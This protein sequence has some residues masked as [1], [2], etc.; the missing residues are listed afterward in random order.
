ME[1]EKDSKDSRKDAGLPQLKVAIVGGGIV[2]LAIARQLS[3]KGHGVT[4]FEKESRWGYHQTGHNSGV[5]HA[6]PYYKPGSLKAKMCLE[7]NRSMFAFAAKHNIPHEKCGK[8]ILAT[9]PKEV[10][11]LNSLAERAKQNGVNCRI[12]SA[13]EAKKY[14]PYSN[15]LLAL[16]VE[17]TGIIDYSKVSEKLAELA[18]ENG[19]ILNLN[20][21]VVSISN[22]GSKVIVGLHGKK[23]SFDFLI[24][25]SGLY[26]DVVAKMAGF[27]PN[28]KIVPFRGE[29]FE[30]VDDR[31]HLVN[32]LIYPVPDP[33]MPFLGVHL[34]R[35]INGEVHAGP[36]AVFA[37]AREGYKWRNI[38]LVET[39]KTMIYSGF[40]RLVLNNFKIGILE[41]FRSI[42]K[43][44]FA[45]DLS[46]LVP[47]IRSN[48][49][50]RSNSGVRAQAIN[51]DG[52]LVDDFVI[53]RNVN[54]IHILNAPSPAATSSLE[55]AKYINKLI[56][57]TE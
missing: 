33:D 25:A 38:N 37:L 34:T 39:S 55:I 54:Q 23:E 44:K 29:Y 53:Q 57:E 35:M 3:E 9:T 52:T 4:L 5:I 28:I 10:E 47:D 11:R 7:G 45:S 27:I 17:D 41:I 20:S 26:S 24:N 50:V 16:R 40:L 14:E 43:T 15:C 31:K 42:V 12:I 21:K 36:N 30:L 49:L 32:G 18:R 48:D 22:I 1:F 2:G 6:G 19:A 51:E 8:L 13:E 46:R 56:D